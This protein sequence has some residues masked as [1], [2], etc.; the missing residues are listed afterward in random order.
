MLSS[1][2]FICSRM[3]CTIKSRF[4]YMVCCS[5]GTPMTAFTLTIGSRSHDSSGFQTARMVP[6]SAAPAVAVAEV[7][8]VEVVVIAV[9]E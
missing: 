9:L 3:G 2:S 7:A 4:S 5:V 1:A 6:S 8:E